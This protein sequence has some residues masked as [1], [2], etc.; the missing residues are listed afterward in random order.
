M[1]NVHT[2]I[3]IFS[4]YA[5]GVAPTSKTDVMK[6]FGNLSKFGG[7]IYLDGN[8]SLVILEEVTQ[9]AENF[10]STQDG[11]FFAIEPQ[12]EEVEE[13]TEGDENE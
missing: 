8:G 6:E 13:N 2:R 7:E 4:F 9:V 5:D 1:S 11:K 10:Y 12:A 3:T